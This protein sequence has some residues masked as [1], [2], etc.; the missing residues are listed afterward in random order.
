[1]NIGVVMFYDQPI[2]SYGKLNYQINKHYCEKHNFKLIL[3]T[4]KKLQNRHSAWERLLLLLDNIANFDYLVW[5]D[6]DAFFY[7]D[8]KNIVEIINAHPNINFIFSNDIGDKN[9]NTGVFIVKNSE[10]SVKFLNKWLYD[11]ELYKKN[12]HPGWWD[13]GV[14][15]DMYNRNI[16]DIR[17]NCVHLNYGILQ[18]FH[19][20]DKVEN[21]S[22]IYHL[23]GRGAAQRCEISKQYLK[24]L[25]TGDFDL[26][27]TRTINVLTCN[28]GHKRH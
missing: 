26:P 4:N 8:A 10:Y 3:S 15:I 21:V 9:I 22:L 7:E 28:L 12:P 27:E 16:L 13:Q 17:E 14:L 11:E 1:M 19:D 5:V 18:H 25:K 24:T 6:A 23:A 2:E 20:N